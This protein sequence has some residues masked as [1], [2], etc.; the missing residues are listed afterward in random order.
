MGDHEDLADP[1]GG[2]E[3]TVVRNKETLESVVREKVRQ[4]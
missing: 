2:C 3:F 1:R 4:R